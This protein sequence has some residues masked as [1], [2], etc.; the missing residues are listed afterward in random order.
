MPRSKSTRSLFL[1]PY[2]IYA[3]R[4]FNEPKNRPGR[5][6]YLLTSR[7]LADKPL[8]SA[9]SRSSN[10][11]GLSAL[12]T[13]AIHKLQERRRCLTVRHRPVAGG[14]TTKTRHSPQDAL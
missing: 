6:R 3:I 2:L 13:I 7:S 11:K 5:S 10:R 4:S 1:S 12:C 8:C 9:A 14:G